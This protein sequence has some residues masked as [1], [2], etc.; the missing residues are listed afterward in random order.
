MPYPRPSWITTLTLAV[1]GGL[2]SIASIAW[3]QDA[4]RWEIVPH[5]AARLISGATHQ[6]ADGVWLRAGVEIRLEPSWHTYWRYPGD[7]G[8]PPTFDFADS[9]N[10][11]SVDVLWPA[12]EVFADGSG[13][14]SVG[15]FGDVVFPLRITALDATRPAK[16]SVK[17]GY[18]ICR[19]LCLPAEAYLALDLPGN[20]G[21]EESALIAAE[22]RVPRRVRLG[23]ETDTGL[24]VR[25]LHRERGGGHDRVSVDVSAPTGI[26]IDLIVEGPTL[27]LGAVAAPAGYM[28]GNLSGLQQFTFD[29]DALPP[30]ANS[31]DAA[32]TF[33][34]VSPDDAIEVS[35]QLP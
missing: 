2:G 31:S 29:A 35:A 21:A 27:G 28:S 18:A 22:A 8:V 4:S 14:H 7:A 16:L 12:P 13:G 6:D 5:G 33:T 9:E 19:N 25:A 24:A 20:A 11:K 34:A 26:P 15:Y 32:L 30:S 3:A 23:A 17:L 10:I 1:F